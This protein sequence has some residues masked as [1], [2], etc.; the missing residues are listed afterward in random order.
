M[1]SL[2]QADIWTAIQSGIDTSPKSAGGG[3]LPPPYIHPLVKKSSQLLSQKSLEICTES[4]GSESGSEFS[5]SDS[6]YYNS[7][8]SDS[9]SDSESSELKSMNEHISSYKYKTEYNSELMTTVNYHC[10]GGVG[11]GRAFPPPL[12]SIARRDGRPCLRMRPHRQDGRLV[13]EA[14]PVK[15]NTYLHAN[16]NNGCLRLSF[17]D[18]LSSSS[19]NASSDSE[20]QNATEFLPLEEK[21]VEVEKQVQQEEEVVAEEEKETT[22]EQQ[23]EEEMEEEEVE[24]VERRTVI[25]VK[26]STQNVKTHRSSLVLNKFLGGTPDAEAAADRPPSPS[27]RG[28]AA[29]A[30]TSAAAA[31]VAAASSS[32]NDNEAVDGYDLGDTK[33]LFTSRRRDTEELLRSVR[34]C[35]QLRRPLFFWEPCC[36]ATSS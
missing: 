10:S 34:R 30:A 5:A 22:E 31:V 11:G 28:P 21:V 2:D 20:V 15:S 24:V 36:I 4:L 27:R 33:L 17:I 26:V 32:L 7:A 19:S 14:V 18:C 16:R 12:P 6:E 1:P 25:E 13:V 3:Q 8:S 9:E 35:S 23:E 29:T